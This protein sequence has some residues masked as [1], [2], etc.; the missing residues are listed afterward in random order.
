MSKVI[1]L[2]QKIFKAAELLSKPMAGDLREKL[3]A[4]DAKLWAELGQAEGE[5]L[6]AN[7]RACVLELYSSCDKAAKGGVCLACYRDRILHDNTG[8][9]ILYREGLRIISSEVLH[10]AASFSP[11]RRVA[12][13]NEM[14]RRFHNDPLD[15]YNWW[16]EQVVQ[17][18]LF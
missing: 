10:K 15:F 2:H 18:E 14:R 6:L 17:K 11:E 1:E 7:P 12:Y 16:Q 3:L 8:W 13:I 9:P 5:I 4:K